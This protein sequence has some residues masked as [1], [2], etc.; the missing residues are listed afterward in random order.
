M[1]HNSCQLWSPRDL[2]SPFSS[3][4]LQCNCTQAL[5]QTPRSPPPQ[6][7]VNQQHT[8][9]SPIS[10][11][12]DPFCHI[13]PPGPWSQVPCAS[14]TLPVAFPLGRQ[15]QHAFGEG[16]RHLGPQFSSHSVSTPLPHLSS[17]SIPRAL[18]AANSS[19]GH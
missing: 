13:G 5:C 1:G 4:V 16:Q 19:E 12:P 18:Q 2:I 11:L 7:G 15:Q 14:L 6:P 10:N 9:T 3:A 8:S 17:H